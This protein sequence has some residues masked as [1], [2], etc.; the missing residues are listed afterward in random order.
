MYRNIHKVFLIF[1]VVPVFSSQAESQNPPFGIPDQTDCRVGN[2]YY[3][4]CI[5]RPPEVTV[6]SYNCQPE[7][8]GAVTF[9]LCNMEQEPVRVLAIDPSGQTF[10][11][12]VSP[13]LPLKIKPNA[14]VKMSA[15]GL[16]GRGFDCSGD[17]G[18]GYDVES[19]SKK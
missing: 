11:E 14:C 16:E 9:E 4:G 7:S 17:Y 10:A 15:R 12:H 18:F 5:T 3:E 6:P 8:W 13:K 2:K 19:Q 1:A